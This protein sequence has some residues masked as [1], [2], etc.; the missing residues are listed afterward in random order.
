MN[1]K[2]PRNHHTSTKH[3][4]SLNE[5]MEK[6]YKNPEA[7][8][9]Q[10]IQFLFPT[11]YVCKE[12][13]HTEYAWLQTK[14]V[15]QCKR[16]SHQTH[17]LAGTVTQDS[18]LSFYQILLGLFFFVSTQSGISGTILAQYMSVNVNTAR[19]FLRKVRCATQIS[20]E[21]VILKGSVELDCGN[22]GGVDEGGKRGAGAKK[23]SIAVAVEFEEGVN[24]KIIRYDTQAKH[25]LP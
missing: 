10:F 21:S 23:Q 2:N 4:F 15:C 24:K 7:Q 12:C 3:C 17:L 18:K 6:F 8:L 22:L 20:N 14:R 11:G 25:A 13:G 1:S 19:L 16:C 9:N 5:F